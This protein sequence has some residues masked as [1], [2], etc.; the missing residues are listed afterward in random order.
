MF[1]E[2]DSVSVFDDGLGLE[3]KESSYK[4]LASTSTRTYVRNAMDVYGFDTESIE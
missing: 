1:G 4:Q 3:A 2:D